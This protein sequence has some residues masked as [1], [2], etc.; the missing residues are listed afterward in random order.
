MN[1]NELADMEASVQETVID[2]D[3]EIDWLEKQLTEM[4]R[5][6]Q[7]TACLFKLHKFMRKDDAMKANHVTLL[8]VRGVIQYLQS[9]LRRVK[10][11]ARNNGH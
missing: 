4:R 6:E 11:N 7:D 2:P 9:E 1:E 10:G 5:L 8:E 3:D